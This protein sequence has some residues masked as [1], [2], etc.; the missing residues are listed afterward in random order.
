MFKQILGEWK[1]KWYLGCWRVTLIALPIVRRLVP[2]IPGI[3]NDIA[4]PGQDERAYSRVPLHALASMRQLWRVV[5]IDLPMVEQPVLLFRSRTDHVV[6]PSSARMIMQRISSSEA[7][8]RILH[9]S[10]HV[11]TLDYDAETIFAESADFF[12][13]H[14]G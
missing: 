8:E 13:R 4:K 10:W 7:T 14:A 11:A 3:A 6:D 12:R 9:R 1:F 2:S 5:R